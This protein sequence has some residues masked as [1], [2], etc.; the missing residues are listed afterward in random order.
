MGITFVTGGFEMP[1]SP[2][3]LRWQADGFGNAAEAA[4]SPMPLVD[5]GVIWRITQVVLGLASESIPQS[6]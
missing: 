3:I 6:G 5:S 1:T 4:D 2:G